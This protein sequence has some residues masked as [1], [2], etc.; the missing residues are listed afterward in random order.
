MEIPKKDADSI[1]RLAKEGKQIKKIMLE[2]FPAYNYAEIYFTVYS[3]GGMSALGAKRTISRRLIKLVSTKSKAERE[4]IINEVDEL[5]L[6]LY[7]SVKNSQKKLD[8][9]RKSLS[10]KD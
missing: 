8:S 10:K 6:H 1:K 7:E 4:E 9:I 2:D 5:V 3:D